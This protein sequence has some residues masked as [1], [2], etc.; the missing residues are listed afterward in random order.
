MVAPV[1]TELKTWPQILSTQTTGVPFWAV[2]SLLLVA[3]GMVNQSV[4][5][6]VPTRLPVPVPPEMEKDFGVS[7]A[8]G[9]FGWAGTAGCW[10]SLQAVYWIPQKFLSILTQ[11]L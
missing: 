3:Q 1:W 7:E 5:H 8:A 9:V 6:W 2:G 11:M 4:V 10:L